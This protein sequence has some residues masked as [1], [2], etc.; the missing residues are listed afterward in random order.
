VLLMCLFTGVSFFNLVVLPFLVFVSFAC[1]NRRL[2]QCWYIMT[3]RGIVLCYI[4][5]NTDYIITTSGADH[6]RICTGPTSLTSLQ[7]SLRSIHTFAFETSSLLHF[8]II[9]LPSSKR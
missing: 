8:M 2:I 3:D 6:M 5:I 7:A 4:I 9:H 1:G